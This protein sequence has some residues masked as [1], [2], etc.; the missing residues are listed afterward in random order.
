MMSKSLALVAAAS[1]LAACASSAPPTSS[2]GSRPAPSR[3]EKASVTLAGEPRHT[4]ASPASLDAA[5]YAALERGVLAELN[6]V[7]TDP[8]GYAD[9]L[10]S[11]LRYYDGSAFRAPGDPVVLK[12]REGADAVREAIG[13]LRATKPMP[14]LRLSAGM[15]HGARDHVADQGP[16]GALDHQGSDG[17]M[18]WDRVDRYGE[19][20]KRVSE[21]LAFGPPSAREV[22]AELLIDDGVRDRG[23]RKNILDPEMH[24]AGVSCG[25]HRRY[26]V[27]CVVVHAVDYTE[28]SRQQRGK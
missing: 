20:K 10:E 26:R 24:V 22:V 1:L 15:S 19:W 11:R 5:G 7:R 6:R 21:N 16:R 12:T 18:A 23:H 28:G 2:H 4:D 13:V 14:A 3:G 8:R 17:S 25:P 27:M 9:V